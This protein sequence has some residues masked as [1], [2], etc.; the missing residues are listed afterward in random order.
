MVIKYSVCALGIVSQAGTALGW[1]QKKQ[2]HLLITQPKIRLWST[3]TECKVFSTL[4]SKK[5]FLSTMWYHYFS[6]EINK[7]L[8]E[9]SWW[10]YLEHHDT[11]SFSIENVYRYQIYKSSHDPIQF[12]GGHLFLHAPNINWAHTI[13]QALLQVPTANKTHKIPA[14]IELI[15]EISKNIYL[16]ITTIL[17]ILFM[18]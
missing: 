2:A 7:F 12:S 15:M 10:H 17:L 18:L 3:D 6:K 1:K 11:L 8:Q 9:C 13:F 16:S 14:L 5:M 4:W